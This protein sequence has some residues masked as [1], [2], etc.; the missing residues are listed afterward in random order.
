MSAESIDKLSGFVVIT[1]ASSGI[2]LELARRAGEDGCDLLLVANEPLTKGEAAARDAGAGAIET[3][4]ADLATESG[5]DE[6]VAKI[7]NRPVDALFANAG[8][9]KGGKFLEHDW[10]QIKQTLDTNVTGTI[11]L[12][13]TVA[14]RMTARGTG[15]ILVT[16]SIVGEMPGPFN[17]TYNSTKAFINM[18]CVGLANELK[19]TGVVITC[20]TPGA[21]DTPFFEKANMEDAPVAEG[22]QADPADVA[23]T[24]YEALLD[25]ELQTADSLSAKFQMI[26]AEILPDGAVASLHRK[27]AKAD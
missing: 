14:N 26:M 1:G 22:P 11:S 15:R 25:G 5:I 10:D 18:F 23:R 12:I 16:G 27:M 19:D 3:L 4:V 24:G 9:S 6:L 17:L 8:R 20:L 2:G 21:V 13:H 7:G